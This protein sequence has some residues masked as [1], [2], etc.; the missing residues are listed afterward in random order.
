[1]WNPALTNEENLNLIQGTLIYAPTKSAH[2]HFTRPDMKP[3]AL[4]LFG[5]LLAATSL[6][7]QTPLNTNLVV[8]PGAEA[9]TG[10][11]NFTSTAPLPGW[12]T[13]LNFTPVQYATGGTDNTLL[14]PTD[15]AAVQGGVNFFAGGPGGGTATASQTIN[16]A[17]LAAQVNTGNLFANLSGYL[18]GYLNQNDNTTLSATFRNSGGLA[19]GTLTLGPVLPAARGNDTTLIQNVGSTPIPIGSVSADI[20][21]TATPFDGSYNDGYADNIGFAIV[22]PEPSTWACVL[23]GLA[24]LLGL[25]RRRQRL[26]A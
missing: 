5:F 3:H 23:G 14:N 21:L 20:V 18:G 12:T 7:A 22:V 19:L 2:H 8:N 6:G 16:F 26:R 15:S 17:D 11:S 25:G 10:A 9:S 24:V 1:M 4:A 13:T